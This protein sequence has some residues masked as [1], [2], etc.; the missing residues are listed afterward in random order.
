MKIKDV[1]DDY[2]G[3]NLVGY[4]K[5]I[6]DDAPESVKKAYWEHRKELENYIKAGKPIPK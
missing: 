4:I 2:L 1:W 6:R 3:D 5:E